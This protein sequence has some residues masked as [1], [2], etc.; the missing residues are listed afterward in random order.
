M[1]RLKIK[2]KRNTAFGSDFEIVNSMELPDCLTELLRA[3][4]YRLIPTTCFHT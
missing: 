1:K 4:G 3:T 2:T